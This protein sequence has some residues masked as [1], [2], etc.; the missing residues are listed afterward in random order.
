MRPQASLPP[1]DAYSEAKAIDRQTRLLVAAILFVG[2]GACAFFMTPF[3]M[4]AAAILLFLVYGAAG[5]I[6]ALVLVLAALMVIG[7]MFQLLVVVLTRVF[8][9]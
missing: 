9:R 2:L 4:P 3:W 5:P 7:G 6:G 1:E 8:G